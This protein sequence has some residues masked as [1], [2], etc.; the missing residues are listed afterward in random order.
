M[1]TFPKLNTTKKENFHDS[2]EESDFSANGITQRSPQLYISSA[3]M[4]V[5]VF[6]TCKSFPQAIMFN[7]RLEYENH[8]P[9]S[10]EMSRC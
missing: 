3:L 4:C 5:C 2:A 1:L 7:L 8:V 9:R 10:F 6:F